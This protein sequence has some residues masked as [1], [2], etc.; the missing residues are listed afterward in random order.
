MSPLPDK[1]TVILISIAGVVV[2]IG[3][4][5]VLQVRLRFLAN[6]RV[7]DA[8]IVD[9]IW[10]STSAGVGH[11]VAGGYRYYPVVEIPNAHGEM[12]RIKS[13]DSR[14]EPPFRVGDRM[15]ALCSLTSPQE[16]NTPSTAYIWLPV[17]IVFA[18]SLFFFLPLLLRLFLT[19][20]H[21][22]TGK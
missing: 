22:V 17:L 8:K 14:K 3:G 21:S 2:L 7:Y 10:E 18:I 11:G 4:L 20:K 16:C 6:A 12:V 15:L 13:F 1:G 5:L 9:V 19:K